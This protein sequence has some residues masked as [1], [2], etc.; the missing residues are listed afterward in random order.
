VI[1]YATILGEMSWFR[2][3]HQFVIV[4]DCHVNVLALSTVLVTQHTLQDFDLMTEDTYRI[5]FDGTI[6]EEYDLET[7]KKR[8]AKY[9]KLNAKQ[10]ERLFSGDEH[11]LKTGISEEESMKYAMAIANIGCECYIEPVPFDDDISKQPGFVERRRGGERRVNP[12]RRKA[13]RGTS[14]R[15]DRRQNNGRR[16]T[17]KND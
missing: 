17:D 7:T 5:V 1:S 11:I 15:P 16:K 10:A 12:S 14:I 13:V 8:F 2:S 9:F 3:G 6:T 4:T